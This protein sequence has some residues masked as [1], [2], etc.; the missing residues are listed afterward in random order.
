MKFVIAP[1]PVHSPGAQSLIHAAQDELDRRYGPADT[2]KGELHVDDMVPPRG[3]FI[4]ARLDG[5][6]AAG[7]AVRSIGLAEHHY[8]E[9]KRLWVRPDLRGSGVAHLLM[10]AVEQEARRLDMVQL[11]LETGDRQPE[12]HAFYAK[13]GWHR[14]DAFPDGAWSYPQGLKFSKFL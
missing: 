13:T 9:I 6:L 10:N 7:V 14:V 3:A 5:H 12:A 11:F 2:D 8:G 4:V 1:E